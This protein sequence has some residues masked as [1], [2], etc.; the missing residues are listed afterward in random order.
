[1][2]E[3]DESTN[4]L[5]LGLWGRSLM[6]TLAAI[7]GILSALIWIY[8][9]LARGFFWRITATALA[10]SEP[11]EPSLRAAAIVPARDEAATIGTV[12]RGLLSQHGV[13]MPVFLVDDGSSDGTA[14]VARAAAAKLG[15]S[16]LLTVV[17]SGPLPPGWTGK[18]WAMQQG[19]TRAQE[20]NPEWLLLA[21]ADVLQAENT[22]SSLAGIAA[23]GQFDMASYMVR[24]HCA[25]LAEKLLIP[26][27]VYFF[28]KLYPPA[29]IQKA[30]NQMAGAAGGCVLL[31]SSALERAG[32]LERIRGEIIDDCSLA[33]LVKQSGGRLWL[34]LN[35]ES[36]SLREYDGFSAIEQM[37]SRTAFSQ[38]NHS[39]L[40]LLGTIVGMVLTYLVPPL[41]LFSGSRVPVILGAVAWTIMTATYLGM[42]RYYRLSP[43]RALTL[44]LAA[45]FYVG[46]TIHSAFKYWMG[47]GGEWKGRVQ[48]L[49]AQRGHTSGVH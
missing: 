2:L 39:S 3:N 16:D 4:L 33:R 34:G 22:V 46:A 18:L 32:G 12:I 20:L 36:R 8:L 10:H 30:E 15:K 38:L 13:R 11:A 25:S 44:P 37:V 48:D 24:L 29:W 19:I 45:L 26:A 23:H 42:V 35:D 47:A 14:D 21:D 40:L 7:L 43:L 1:M 6:L 41:L 31:R 49:S 9:L 17:E 5:S 28:F 27:F